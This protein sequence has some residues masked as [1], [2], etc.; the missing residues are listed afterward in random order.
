MFC[1]NMFRNVSARRRKLYL[2]V[3]VKNGYTLNFLDFFNQK[4]I[5]VIVIM[6]QLL[7]DEAGGWVGFRMKTDLFKIGEMS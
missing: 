5:K 2:Y 6:K 4:T 3:Q 7:F 1:A